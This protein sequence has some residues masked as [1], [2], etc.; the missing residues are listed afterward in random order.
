MSSRLNL[1][2]REELG[3]AYDATAFY[4][5]FEAAGTVGLYIATAID[6]RK[7]AT[8]EMRRIA[9]GLITRPI[10]AVELG[11]AK[12]QLIGS[13]VL[14]MESVTNRMM[15]SAQNM[16]YF[17]GYQPIERD[18]EKIARLTIEEVR[19]EATRLFADEKALLLV[20][21]V[22]QATDE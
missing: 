12:E 20:S 16:L 19:A 1:R 10:S 22:P 6:N 5:P 8:S 7:R 15:R 11:R 4:A 2:L 3:L 14:P 18:V 13:L 21:V 17:G 9:R